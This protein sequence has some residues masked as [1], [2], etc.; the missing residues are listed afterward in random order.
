M[1]LTTPPL[2]TTR[3]WIATSVLILPALLASMDLSVLFMGSPWISADLAPTAS[4]HLWIMDIYGFVMAGLLITMGSVGDRIGRRK[5]LLIGAVAF[6]T[7]SALAAFASSAEMLIAARALLGLGGATLAPSTLSLIR[8]MFHD[9]NQRRT[10]VGIWTGAFTG[11]VAIGPIIGGLLL[12]HFHWGSVF[13]INIPVMALLLIVAPL[14]IREARDP[15][16]GRFDLL[17]AALSLAAILPL[18]YG[19]KKTAEDGAGWASVAAI[20]V[21]AIFAA[22]FVVRQRTTPSPMIDVHLFARPAFSGSIIAN[23]IVVFATAGMGLLSVT[24]MQTVLGFA[25]LAAALWMLPTVAGSFLGVAIA[26]LLA[27]TVRPAL[28]VSTGLLVA[29]VGFA[30]VSLVTPDSHVGLLIVAYSTLTLGV[31]MTATMVTSLVLTTAPPEKAGAASALAETSSEFGG[32][33]G[34]AT[35]GTLAGTIYRGAMTANPVPGAENAAEAAGDTVGAAVAAA[36]ELPAEVADLLLRQAFDA[37]THGL[38]VAAVVGAAVLALAAV[39]AGLA[40]RTVTT[41]QSTSTEE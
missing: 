32:A 7:A 11:G 35:L 1:T 16:P 2:A 27:R 29:A 10:A 14:V 21:G 26:S 3:E 9:E 30:G 13:L 12:E 33:L 24:F 8:G 39:C 20:V 25:P 15:H 23:A 28:L 34:I 5:L 18:V 4:Q 31:G 19:I 41:P 37:Y 36:Q 40:L 38:S 6:G 17:G 22:L